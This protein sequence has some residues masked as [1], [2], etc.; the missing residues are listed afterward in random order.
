V[1][2]AV[3]QVALAARAAARPQA[4]GP[5]RKG[6]R[7]GKAR[8]AT[9]A[10][11][12]AVVL[13]GG[14]GA[15]AYATTRGT[16]T[17]YVTARASTQ[18][19]LQTLH[20]T[21]TTEPSS[22]ATVSFAVSGTVATVPVAMGDKVTAGQVL[23]TL[24][25]SALKYAVATAQGQV[26]NAD[27]TLTQAE[28]GQVSTTS[29]AGASGAFEGGRVGHGRTQADG[30]ARVQPHAPLGDGSGTGHFGPSQC[31]NRRL[32]PGNQRPQTALPSRPQV[33]Y[34]FPDGP[35]TTD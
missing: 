34:K 2:G 11:I 10:G 13:V 7:T 19:V 27:L 24:D 32:I 18:S 22:A 23:A 33:H 4:P 12:S 31:K 15:V 29:G 14:G 28:N 30:A 21:G 35:W 9:A 17:T 8:V 5:M 16:A 1:A 20:A 3:L 26:A 25:N 6:G